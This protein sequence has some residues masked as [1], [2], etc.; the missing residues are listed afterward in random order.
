MNH[1]IT[2]GVLTV[3]IAERG[4]EIQ[5]ITAADGTEFFW[6]ADPSVWPKHG[7][8]LFPY[9]ASLTEGKYTLDGQ[10]YEMGLHGFVPYSAL[11][12]ESKSESTAS[13]CLC[14][15]ADTRKAYPFTFVYHVTYT[16][17]G[18]RLTVTYTVENKDCTPMYFGIGGHPGFHMPIE[19]GLAFEDFSLHFEAPCTASRVTFGPHGGV[20]GETDYSIPAGV[21]P[22]DHSLFSS[23]AIVLRNSGHSIAI[24][25]EKSSKAVKVS[26]PQMPY[27][28]IWQTPNSNFP[29][30]CIEPWSSLPSRD[31]IIEDLAKQDNLV[32]LP[33]GETYRNSWT[34][35]FSF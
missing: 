35:D 29:F 22:L 15:N 16:L 20:S 1:V 30:L 23:G 5:S 25:S 14:D 27:V 2:N 3:A 6:N 21:I 33:A 13:F 31:G 19:P 24:R 10:T 8:N 32:T 4:A 12:L 26:F 34:M 17:E 18:S 7:P 9:L 28:G 11:T